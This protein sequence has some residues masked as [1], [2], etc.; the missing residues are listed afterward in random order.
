MWWESMTLLQQILFVLASSATAIMIIF[1]IMM[2]L[3]FETDEFDGSDVPDLTGDSINDDPLTGIAGLKVLTLRGILVLVSIGGWTAYLLVESLM[4]WL[5]ILIGIVVGIVAAYLQALAFRA[6]L[7]LES[8]GNLDYKNAI[9]LHGTV[10]MRVPK[11]KI[12]KGKV[13]VNIQDRLV[14]IDAITDEEQDILPKTSVIVTGLEDP[15]TIIV[16]TK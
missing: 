16:K 9:G 15:T 6:T 12:G 14:E 8:E 11:N 5:A 2:L 3:G 1:L 13:T 10:Y 7:R 4:P